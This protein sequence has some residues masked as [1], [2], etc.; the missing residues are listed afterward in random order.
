MQRPSLGFPESRAGTSFHVSG[1]PSPATH[2]RVRRDPLW[3]IVSLSVVV[4]LTLGWLDLNGV[5][6]V[7]VVVGGSP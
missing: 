5:A 4:T 1:D 7:S 3:I 6:V 2:D